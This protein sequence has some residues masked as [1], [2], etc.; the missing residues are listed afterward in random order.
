MHGRLGV[1]AVQSSKPPRRWSK[2]SVVLV[3]SSLIGGVAVL[4]MGVVGF[5]RSVGFVMHA[6]DAVGD[7]GQSAPERASPA[8][9]VVTASGPTS[10]VTQT[11]PSPSGAGDSGPSA[12]AVP[13]VAAPVASAAAAAGGANDAVAAREAEA[14]PLAV[15]GVAGGSGG[16][17]TDA[18]GGVAGAAPTFWEN[19]VQTVLALVAQTTVSM[20]GPNTCNTGQVCCN[21]SCGICVAP[22][23]SCDTTPC[24][25]AAR[26]PTAVR[27]G[28]AQC[29][30]GQ[31]CCN[32]SCGI[33]AAPG[34]TCSDQQCP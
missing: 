20:C 10:S 16:G 5:A 2:R 33:C 17:G 6:V 29:N 11:S 26:A 7:V 30:D 34:E 18:T 12:G 32:A 3:V 31:V 28:S 4:V 14:S 27:C 15:G 1:Q 13:V 25:G 8:S 9:N 24:A 22:G 23:S 21:A 19:V